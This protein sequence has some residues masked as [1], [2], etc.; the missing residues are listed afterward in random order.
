MDAPEYAQMAVQMFRANPD[1]RNRDYCHIYVELCTWALCLCEFVYEPMKP[2]FSDL[3]S[4]MSQAFELSLERGQPNCGSHTTVRS[5]SHW[6]HSAA[7][8]AL[9][10]LIPQ[11]IL[12]V[13]EKGLDNGLL[14]DDRRDFEMLKERWQQTFSLPAQPQPSDHG[15]TSQYNEKSDVSTQELPV[16]LER[17]IP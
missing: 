8:G 2:I 9:V 7:D 10:P 5:W 11:S 12:V 3:F 16:P 17:V 6:M 4:S 15:D 1:Y 14:D 13:M